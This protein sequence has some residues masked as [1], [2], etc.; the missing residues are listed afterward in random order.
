MSFAEVNLFKEELTHLSKM[1]QKAKKKKVQSCQK[2]RSRGSSIIIRLSNIASLRA[3]LTQ[4]S[5]RQNNMRTFRCRD[6]TFRCFI[7]ALLIDAAAATRD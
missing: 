5:R 1:S 3:L 6:L 7:A 2:D 4:L